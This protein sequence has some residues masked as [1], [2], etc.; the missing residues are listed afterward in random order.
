MAT[1][2]STFRIEPRSTRTQV[3]GRF[4]KAMKSVSGKSVTMASAKNGRFE[5]KK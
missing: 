4:V 5:K 1:R 3:S 2:K